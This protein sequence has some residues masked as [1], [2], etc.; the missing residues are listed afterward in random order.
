[1]SI[2]G[3][4]NINK[5]K[6]YTSQ[7]I[8]SI[9]KKLTKCKAGHTGTLDPNATG[10]L[11]VCLGRATKIADYIMAGDKEYAAEVILGSATDT[12]DATGTVIDKKTADVDFAKIKDVLQEFIGTIEQIPPMYSAIKIGGKKLYEYARQNVEIERKPRQIKISGIDILSENLPDSF[13]IRVNCSK[14]TYIRTLCADIGEKLG[15]LAHM[16]DL[17]RTRSGSFCIEDSISLEEL[18]IN[19]RNGNFQEHIITID[20]TLDYLPKIIISTNA[21]KLIKNGNKIPLNFVISEKPLEPDAEYL[22]F[23]SFGSII[24]IHILTDCEYI[25]PKVYLL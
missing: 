20:N 19:V 23:D 21:D 9:V 12:Q 7:D 14:G 8:V 11:P 2:S 3:I 22:A 5:P 1:M 25:K 24:G 6:G 13:K 15:T 4:I 10:V 18:E 17:E 16:G